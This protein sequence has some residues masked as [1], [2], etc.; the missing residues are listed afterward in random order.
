M[1]VYTFKVRFKDGTRE[2]KE[3][4]AK[5]VA[6]ADDAISKYVGNSKKEYLSYELVSVKYKN[7][8]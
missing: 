4:V 5:S 2:T 1:N 8:E 7:D 3:L 6:K